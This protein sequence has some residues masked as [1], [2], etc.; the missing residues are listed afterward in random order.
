MVASKQVDVPLFR[1]FG[2]QRGR[3]FSALAQ[4]YGRTAVPFLRES[5]VPAAKH[6]GA[7]LL[8]FV[9]P[10]FA[11]VVSGRKKFKTAA[12]NVGRQIPRNQLGSSRRKKLQAESLQKALQNKAVGRQIRSYKHFS[13]FISSSFRY[14]PFVAVSGNLGEKNA[15]VDDVLLSHKHYNHPTTS[16]DENCIE[17]E[18]QTDRN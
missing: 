11:E 9:G 10:E 1:G 5:I 17:F 14:S 16:L 15:I 3:G 8:E 7:G 4:V 12:K 13:K 6:V 18:F 2:R